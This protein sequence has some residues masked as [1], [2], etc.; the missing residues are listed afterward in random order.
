MNLAV[1]AIAMNPC[2]NQ[3]DQERFEV[4]LKQLIKRCEF[5]V[6]GVSER[7]EETQPLLIR[8]TIVSRI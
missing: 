8:Y 4:C 3:A 1:K 6:E 2:C 5:D 7:E